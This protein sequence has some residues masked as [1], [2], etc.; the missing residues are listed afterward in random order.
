MEGCFCVHR[1]FA[2]LAL[3]VAVLSLFCSP[4]TAQAAVGGIA[5]LTGDVTPSELDQIGSCGGLDNLNTAA[6]TA[7]ACDAAGMVLQ[8]S[9]A[10]AELLNLEL[11]RLQLD[12]DATLEA[13]A[14]HAALLESLLEQFE[15]PQAEELAGPLLLPYG[16]SSLALSKR[17]QESKKQ[18]ACR[19]S[20]IQSLR[21][22]IDQCMVEGD[23]LF[24][25]ESDVGEIRWE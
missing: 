7:E 22:F 4:G 25:G 17:L 3:H 11:A 20:Q 5:P 15:R 1:C 10:Q 14:T 19:E 21:T 24:S 16:E 8:I 6:P 13:E 12:I 2:G 9:T 23:V 18:L